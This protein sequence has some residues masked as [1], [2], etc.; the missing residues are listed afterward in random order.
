MGRWHW[1]VC[2]QDTATVEQA[3]DWGG[4]EWCDV[5]VLLLGACKVVTECGGGES[6]ALGALY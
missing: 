1:G 3:R 6:S 4:R 5:V 2:S